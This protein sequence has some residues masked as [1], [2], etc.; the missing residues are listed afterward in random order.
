MKLHLY[1]LQALLFTG[2]LVQPAMAGEI[3]ECASRSADTSC[4]G[5]TQNRAGTGIT[6]TIPRDELARQLGMTHG[7]MGAGGNPSDST[8]L[9]SIFG[10]T[11]DTPPSST[12]AGWFSSLSELDQKRFLELAVQDG[13]SDPKGRPF[14]P[15]HFLRKADVLDY[16]LERQG[17]SDEEKILALQEVLGESPAGD[18]PSGGL[19]RSGHRH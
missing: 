14:T 1:L 15:E 8:L 11:A 13:L 7:G 18:E 2:V 4:D 6:G 12:V 16:E 3:A 9:S 19:A 5:F 10:S 17:L